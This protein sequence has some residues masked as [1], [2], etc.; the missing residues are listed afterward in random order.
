MIF[1]AFS[2]PSVHKLQ[3]WTFFYLQTETTAGPL[4]LV[5]KIF[6]AYWIR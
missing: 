5:Q 4:G 6:Y 2:R 1:F 3:F